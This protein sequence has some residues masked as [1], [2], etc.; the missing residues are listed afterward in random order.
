MGCTKLDQ[1]FLPDIRRLVNNGAYSL[2]THTY[3]RMLERGIL[4]EDVKSI[5]TSSTNQIIEIQ[6][7]ATPAFDEKVLITDPYY[8][9]D[10]IV[11]C[12]LFMRGMPDIRIVTV[13]W[14]DFSIWKKELNKVPYLVRK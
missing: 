8:G 13:E 7:P 14:I 3:D 2:R 4:V 1:S 10:I 6:P 5:L 11:I 9:K 12:A